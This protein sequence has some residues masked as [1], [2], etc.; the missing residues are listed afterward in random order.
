MASPTI[1]ETQPTA[2]AGCKLTLHFHRLSPP[3]R[4]CVDWK[5]LCSIPSLIRPR[6]G[7]IY[8][9][10]VSVWAIRANPF[11]QSVS[12]VPLHLVWITLASVSLSVPEYRLQISV[13][14]L[15]RYRFSLAQ[16]WYWWSP[17]FSAKIFNWKICD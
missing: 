12:I 11:R 9:R 2:S 5:C 13:F 4:Y 10:K 17:I 6:N 15:V 16:H 7:T 8:Q 14:V 1:A 3:N